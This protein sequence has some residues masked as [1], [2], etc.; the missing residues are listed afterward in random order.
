V[1]EDGAKSRRSTM[2]ITKEDKS[3]N[4]ERKREGGEGK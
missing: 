2:V 1:K 3:N 4:K